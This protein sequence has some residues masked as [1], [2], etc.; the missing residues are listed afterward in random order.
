[1][2]TATQ[3]VIIA[4]LVRMSGHPVPR[5]LVAEALTLASTAPSPS[6]VRS[7]LARLDRAVTP[8]GLRVWLLSD[9]AVMLEVLPEPAK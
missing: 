4:P 9:H 3:C 1:M 2:P 5:A 6:A 8:L 7:L